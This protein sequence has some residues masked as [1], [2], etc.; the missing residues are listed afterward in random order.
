ML[1]LKKRIREGA[2]SASE[3]SILY[4]NPKGT[5]GSEISELRLTENGEFIDE[6]P[7]GFFEESYLEVLE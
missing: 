4:V 7:D 3:V 6:W 2:I 1:R 5:D